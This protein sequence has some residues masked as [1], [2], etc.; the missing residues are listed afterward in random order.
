MP[1]WKGHSWITRVNGRDGWTWRGTRR[2]KV[3]AVLREGQDSRQI[4]GKERIGSKINTSDVNWNY[5]WDTRD[6]NRWMCVKKKKKQCSCDE[7]PQKLLLLGWTGAPVGQ[8]VNPLLVN[9][10]DTDST[11]LSR[12]LSSSIVQ[13]GE[14]L[15]YS[16]LEESLYFNFHMKVMTP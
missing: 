10:K 4:L 7:N 9:W 8:G 13:I 6:T 16:T 3:H 1:Q 11:K 5:G 14:S 15:S 12:K 2:D